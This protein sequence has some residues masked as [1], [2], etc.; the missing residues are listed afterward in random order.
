MRTVP[1]ATVAFW[2]AAAG[3]GSGASPFV[4]LGQAPGFS[5][6]VN[7]YG[8]TIDQSAVDWDFYRNGSQVTRWKKG[9]GS[10][11]PPR[12]SISCRVEGGYSLAAGLRAFWTVPRPNG[13]PKGLSRRG[14]AIWWPLCSGQL[15][16]EENSTG[17]HRRLGGGNWGIIVGVT[18]GE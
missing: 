7:G 2:L 3:V 14:K 9:S 5:V 1:I 10:G 6:T 18:R 4:G 16:N 11:L 12:V 13:R 17:C 8:I 15:T